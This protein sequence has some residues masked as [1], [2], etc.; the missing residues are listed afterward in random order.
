MGLVIFRHSKDR[1]HRDTS[2]LSSLPSGSL[3]YG[4]QV[5][6]HISRIPS[7]S[8]HFFAGRRY[9]TQGICIVCDICQDNKYVHIFSK[10]RYS[11]A[12][13]AIFGVAIRSIAGS[14]ARLTNS[15]VRSI[16]PVSLKLSIK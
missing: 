3:V 11:A 16:A 8:R 7:A 12:V 6:I 13:S 1:D 5:C 4:S 14:F 10:A 2:R 15:T 9:F